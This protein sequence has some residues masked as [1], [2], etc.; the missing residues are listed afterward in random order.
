MTF[1]LWLFA[2]L[3]APATLDNGRCSTC[4]R[5]GQTST[6]EMDS[7]SSCTLLLCV[8]GTGFYDADG[9][10]HPPATSGKCNTCTQSGQ[11]SRG[12]RVTHTY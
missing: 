11:C 12:H 6:V 5:L 1:A 10:F 4:K 7:F 8:G 9:V 2:I 3:L